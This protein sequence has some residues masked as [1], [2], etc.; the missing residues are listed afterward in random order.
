MKTN[1]IKPALPV[2]VILAVLTYLGGQELLEL[3]A[4][5]T[6]L[7][8]AAVIGLG[9]YGAAPGSVTPS[10]DLADFEAGLPDRE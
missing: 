6:V 9:V 8:Q 3:P 4:Y 5:V 7:I 10:Q 1:G 2:A